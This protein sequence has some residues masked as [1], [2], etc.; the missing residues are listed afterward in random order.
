MSANEFNGD[1]FDDMLRETLNFQFP[2][3]PTRNPGTVGSPAPS[4]SASACLLPVS[5]KSLYIFFYLTVLFLCLFLL[6]FC[7][8]E[9]SEWIF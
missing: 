3:I 8:S 1:S 7:G 5:S 4:P 6:Y 2:G 9:T